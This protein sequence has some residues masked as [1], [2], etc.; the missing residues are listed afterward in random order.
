MGVILDLHGDGTATVGFTRTAEVPI[1]EATGNAAARRLYNAGRY[2][3]VDAEGVAI[4]WEDL[5]N[6]QKLSMLGDFVFAA[7]HEEGMAQFDSEHKAEI[8]TYRAADAAKIL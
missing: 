7:I 8:A 2:V 4:P 6:M 3:P 1:I 5:T